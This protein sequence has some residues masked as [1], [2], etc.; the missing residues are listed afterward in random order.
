MPCTIGSDSTS[1]GVA[2]FR[3]PSSCP[4]TSIGASAVGSSKEMSGKEILRPGLWRR[5]RIISIARRVR[6]IF[7]EDDI[8]SPVWSTGPVLDQVRVA[9]LE[10]DWCTIKRLVK[11]SVNQASCSQSMN[12]AGLCVDHFL[13]SS[14]VRVSIPIYSGGKDCI[15]V[16]NLKH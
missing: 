16:A 3:C 8:G 14:I 2:S 11:Q 9:T 1:E 12:Q 5:C 13:I 15:Y 10:A 6:P 7:S 4:P